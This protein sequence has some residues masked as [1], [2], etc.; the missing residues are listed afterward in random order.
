MSLSD[1]EKWVDDKIFVIP[2]SP[3]QISNF[4]IKNKKVLCIVCEF[5]LNP[6]V[7]HK[8]NLTPDYALGN[9]TPGRMPKMKDHLDKCE[10]HKE[11]LP[12]F[13]QSYFSTP[14]KSVHANSPTYFIPPQISLPHF[15]PSSLLFS[16]PVSPPTNSL[17]L[18]SSSLQSP[19][20]TPQTRQP[21]KKIEFPQLSNVTTR[22]MKATAYN[23]TEKNAIEPAQ[24]DKEN[25]LLDALGKRV[26]MIHHIVRN[27]QS[28]GSLCSL[29]DLFDSAVGETTTSLLGHTSP[30]S[31]RGFIMALKT[32]LKE[33]LKRKLKKYR[34]YSIMID[35][36]KDKGGIIEMSV[37]VRFYG[38]NQEVTS[39]LDEKGSSA[40]VLFDLLE[41][42]L[43]DWELDP[44]YIL[45]IGSDGASNMSSYLKGVF[46]LFRDKYK[47]KRLVF[48]HCAAHR[49]NLLAET[50]LSYSDISPS[51]S[52]TLS[53]ISHIAHIFHASPKQKCD[54]DKLVTKF[55]YDV[56]SIPIECDT[57]WL[58]RF[59]R[60]LE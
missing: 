54:L 39:T 38:H 42:V 59:E 48:N 37:Y 46:G 9:G 15:P 20:K 7:K 16:L 45:A 55:G 30:Y 13:L 2:D 52:E 18:S 27:K 56:I 35:D 26:C 25:V 3:D 4:R 6:C 11:S 44:R 1:W 5:G 31:T 12:A 58:S 53:I 8:K 47:I 28:I 24:E 36:S 23:S 60:F 22:N 50:L 33:N 57:R 40:E 41:K 29:Q 10:W 34:Y 43:L 49:C 14:Q 19:P 17:V 51:F 21:P 32:A